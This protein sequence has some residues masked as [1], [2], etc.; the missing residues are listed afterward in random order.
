MFDKSVHLY[1]TLRCTLKCS[2][3][4]N[5]CPGMKQVY[6]YEEKPAECWADLIHK[7]S[8]FNVYLTGGEV[9]LFDN[10]VDIIMGVPKR[11]D[12]F[13]I[14][15]NTTMISDEVVSKLD[16]DRV[17]FRCSY[18]GCSGPPE[19]FMEKIGIL[20]SRSMPLEIFMVDVQEEDALALRTGFFRDRG[21]DIRVDYD[22]RR[23]PHKKGKV[24]CLLNTAII[25]PDGGVYHCV[26]RMVRGKGRGE[27][28][29]RG[30]DL[31]RPKLIT[32]DEPEMCTPCD[33][34]ASCQKEIGE[35]C[36]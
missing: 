20:E 33:L 31:R 10:I 27:D 7:L 11:W 1:P 29:F 14:Y 34:A 9:F 19:K 28:V 16:P 8:G 15:T 3:C 5:R 35:D 17:L 36:A 6:P 18:H 26:S 21:Y 30:E 22:Q 2:Y 12:R 23:H 13:S 24:K 25:S 32:C 4:S